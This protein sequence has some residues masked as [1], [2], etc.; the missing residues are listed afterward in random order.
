MRFQQI[1][2]TGV[3]CVT[4]CLIYLCARMPLYTVCVCLG[5]ISGQTVGY[6]QIIPNI[7]FNT[8]GEPG[9]MVA[10]KLSMD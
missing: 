5:L 9:G 6:L 4:L 8:Q 7:C 2:H 3:A 10:F 1:T